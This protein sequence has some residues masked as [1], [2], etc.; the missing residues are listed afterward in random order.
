MTA[1]LASTKVVRTVLNDASSI[2]GLIVTTEAAMTEHPEKETEPAMPGG[3]MGVG[4]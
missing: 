1:I 2:A 4:F 3:G